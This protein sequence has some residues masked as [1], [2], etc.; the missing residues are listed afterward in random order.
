M[1]RGT[2]GWNEAE[3]VKPRPSRPA[4]PRAARRAASDSVFGALEHDPR[5]GEKRFAG[6]GQLDAAR[7]AP[8]QLDFKLG[9]EGADLLAERR[10]LNAQPLCRASHMTLLGDGH[11]IPEMAHFHSAYAKC[12]VGTVTIY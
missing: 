9:F 7:L 11:K 8:E 3:L 2:R 5:F 10:L 6:R 12:I 4:S 1:T